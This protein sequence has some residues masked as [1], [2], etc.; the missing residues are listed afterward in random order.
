ML[1]SSR[2]EYSEAAAPTRIKS[3]RN[4]RGRADRPDRRD[5]P[6][7]SASAGGIEWPVASR[8]RCLAWYYPSGRKSCSEKI[9]LRLGPGSAK[10][11]GEAHAR[12]VCRIEPK[13]APHHGRLDRK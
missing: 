3:T 7:S 1:G 8:S 13:R 9:W 6:R 4:C 5:R 12:L 11:E 2:C 10:T